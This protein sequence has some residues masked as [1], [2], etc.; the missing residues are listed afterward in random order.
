[1][2]DIGCGSGIH[3]HAAVKLGARRVMS[4]DYDPNSVAAAR[5]LWE[6]AG[7]PPNW[8]IAQG[9]ALDE[10]YIASL[11]K[12]NFVYSW[13]VLHHTGDMWRAVRN[14]F[15][16]V[17]DGGLFY[18]AL[19]SKDV[20]PEADMW[21]R[22][23]KEYV[24]GGWLNRRRREWWYVW[25]YMIGRDFSRLPEFF[26]RMSEHKKNRGMELMTDI[27]DW[28]GG[29]PM[30]FAG[31]QETVDLLEKEGGFRLI[32]VAT[33]EACTEFLFERS[34]TPERVT[35]V[36]TAAAAWKMKMETRASGAAT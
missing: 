2:L 31:D 6:K 13:G 19:Y 10:N 27:R 14:A 1:M 36:K 16:T 34:G 18:L 12:W 25:N 4:F 26:R 24:S 30:E 20:Q 3:S 22:I 15:S 9:D 29:W 21:L 33:G 11:G 8:T 7:S 35:D 17:A 28:L 5:F 23:K 32:N